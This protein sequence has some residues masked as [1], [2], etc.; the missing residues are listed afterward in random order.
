MLFPAPGAYMSN[1]E[2]QYPDHSWKEITGQ[3]ARV[4]ADSGMGKSQL[5]K[6]IE[7]IMRKRKEHDAGPG[8]EKLHK[9]NP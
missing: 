2:F 5:A 7:T 6:C 1:S 8:R 3:L 9:R 4:V